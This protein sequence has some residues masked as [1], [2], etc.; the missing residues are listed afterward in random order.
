ME[1]GAYSCEV[2]EVLAEPLG[3]VEEGPGGPVVEVLADVEGN[4]L[5]EGGVAAAERV[6]EEVA[7]GEAEGEAGGGGPAAGRGEDG[8]VAGG[9][10]GV[11]G[12]VG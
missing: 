2:E 5:P 10:G 12:G 4:D 9:L 7:E 11:E 6:E 3:G 8:H 1:F